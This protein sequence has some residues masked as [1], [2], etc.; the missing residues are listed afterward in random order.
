VDLQ[1][2]GARERAHSLWKRAG[3]KPAGKWL[4]QDQNE[5]HGDVLRFVERN[6]AYAIFGRIPFLT[7]KIPYKDL[8]IMVE[9]D[10]TMRRSY[11]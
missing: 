7:R 10:P 6:H 4:L 5:G 2:I 11:I 1:D 3:M 9:D 8:K